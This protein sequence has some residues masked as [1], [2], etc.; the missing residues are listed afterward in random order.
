[1]TTADAPPRH[2][3]VLL[4]VDG[5]LVDST[6]HHALAW[7]RAFRSQGIDLPM[8]RVHRAIGMGG[9]RLVGALAGD[10]VEERLGDALRD[11]WV[12]E[13]DRLIGEVSP[14]PGAADLVRSLTER[15]FL[16]ALASS[17]KPQHTD[18]ALEML[19]I[20]DLVAAVTTSEDA[21]TSKP[22]PDILQVALDKAGGHSAVVLGDS[23]FDIASA[24]R[25]GAPC[26]AIRT[27]GFGVDELERAGAVLVADGLVELLHADWDALAQASPPERASDEPPVP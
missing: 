9:D 18:K 3:T 23:T 10:E 27:G 22:A 12:A 7:H 25:L 16:V 19:G 1:M 2:D 24:A 5:T 15:G 6:Y 20:A 21:E 4:D 11:G 8:W 14:L 13:Y 17:G 26:V